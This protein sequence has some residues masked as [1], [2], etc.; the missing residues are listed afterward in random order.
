[1]ALAPRVTREALSNCTLVLIICIGAFLQAKKYDRAI[2]ILAKHGWWDKLIEVVRAVDKGDTKNL[3]ACAGHF[4]KAGQF[5]YAKE[6]L[7]KQDD[8]RGLIQLLVDEQK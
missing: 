4:R 2:A 6:A 7:I 3:A 8:M 1:M 5:A